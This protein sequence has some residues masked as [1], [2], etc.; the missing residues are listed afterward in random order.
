M[1]YNR[2]GSKGNDIFERLLDYALVIL[3]LPF[4]FPI[5]L[6]IAILIKLD[7]Q[8]PVLF[9]QER[10]GKNGK[11]FKMFKFRT[12]VADADEGL[13]K[14]QVKAYANGQ[15][16]AA[17]GYKI[18]KDPRITR[19]GQFLRRTSLDELPQ[20]FNV[21]LGEMSLVGPRPVPVYEAEAYDWWQA[22]RLVVLPGITG[23]WQVSGRSEVTFEE[24]SRLDIR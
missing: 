23:M 5:L 1:S 2:S 6:T 16:D 19:A 17:N 20:I 7:S 11:N 12:M 21:L 15:I 22:E 4:L 8:G 14:K 18:E 10:A 24:Q 13:H 3:S 9:L